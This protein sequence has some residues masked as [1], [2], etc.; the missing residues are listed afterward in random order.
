MKQINLFTWMGQRLRSWFTLGLEEEFT[1]YGALAKYNISLA[2]DNLEKLH[3]CC[4]ISIPLLA[5]V[6]VT[7]C[8]LEGAFIPAMWCRSAWLQPSSAASGACCGTR[9]TGW[10]QWSFPTC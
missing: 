8:L 5:F 10:T 4:T 3:D 9:P 1:Q 7:K 2:R 6:L